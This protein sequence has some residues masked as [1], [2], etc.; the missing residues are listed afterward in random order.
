[1]RMHVLLAATFLWGASAADALEPGQHPPCKH[2]GVE[3]SDGATICEC[4]T[5]K[6]VVGYATGGPDGSVTSR[7]LECK[8]GAWVATEPNCAEL[9]G[10]SAYMI[11]EHK[12]LQD[13]YCP[14]PG[15][16]DQASNYI[17]RASPT[18][19]LVILSP[20]CRRFAIPSAVCAAAIEAISKSQ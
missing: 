18:E 20:L 4:P 8:M 3:Y 5:I 7:R 2:G 14:R 13:M 10:G 12:K 6:A 11:E 17:D 16:A 15:F 1:M 19:G 9:T